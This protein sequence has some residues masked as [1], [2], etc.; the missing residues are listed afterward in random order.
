[1]LA[2]SASSCYGDQ[3]SRK[4][5]RIRTAAEFSGCRWRTQQGAVAKKPGLTTGLRRTWH[6]PPRWQTTSGDARRG[7]SIDWIEQ[8]FQSLYLIGPI[9]L[10]LTKS[11]FPLGAV[12][13]VPFRRPTERASK[14]KSAAMNEQALAAEVGDEP[15]R[16]PEATFGLS[17][18]A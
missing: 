6:H 7:T 14:K 11:I 9:R 13:K 12:R 17:P 8:A 5:G 2:L 1:M 15:E 4:P 3:G 18:E 10:P 16:K